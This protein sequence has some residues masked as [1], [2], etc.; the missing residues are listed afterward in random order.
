MP[1][2]SHSGAVRLVSSYTPY[3][4]CYSVGSESAIDLGKRTLGSLTTLGTLKVARFE[5]LLFVVLKHLD[6]VATPSL[7]DRP[8]PALGNDSN[9]VEEEAVC[10]ALTRPMLFRVVSIVTNWEV[11]SRCLFSSKMKISL[12]MGGCLVKAS[13]A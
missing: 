10:N 2:S 4:S 6:C 11:G 1:N 12:A 8:K 13:S 7:E 5:H 3:N 9:L